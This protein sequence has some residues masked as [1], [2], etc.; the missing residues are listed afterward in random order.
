MHLRPARSD[1]HALLTQLAFAAKGHWGYS[2]EQLDS[3]VDELTFTPEYIDS[4]WVTVAEQ[5]GQEPR[6][7]GVCSLDE[8]G[9]KLE[10]AGMW[11]CPQAQGLGVGRRLLEAALG[12]CRERGVAVLRLLSDPHAQGFYA[13][14][15]AVLIGFE[16]GSPTGRLLPLMHF[17]VG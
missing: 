8:A 17:N 6:V 7:V 11:V 1:E 9:A 14:L 10:I 12:H 4:H 13:H 15:G 3:W 16:R 2:R 5:P